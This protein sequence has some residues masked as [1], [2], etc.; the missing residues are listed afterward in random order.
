MPRKMGRVCGGLAAEALAVPV[1]VGLG[2]DELS[3]PVP[4]IAQIKAQVRALDYARCQELARRLLALA[5]GQ[6]VRH[7]LKDAALTTAA[8]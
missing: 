2:V 5:D 3:V 1:L 6:Q 8:T 4:A 7:A